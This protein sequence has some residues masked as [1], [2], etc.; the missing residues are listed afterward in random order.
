MFLSVTNFNTAFAVESFK[1]KEVILFVDSKT[2]ARISFVLF[3]D[4]DLI[5]S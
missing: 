4:D 5:V 1:E 3:S 2:A